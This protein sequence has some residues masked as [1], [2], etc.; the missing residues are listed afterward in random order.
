MLSTVKA[1]YESKEY[2]SVV[3]ILKETLKPQRNTFVEIPSYH[4][5][6]RYNQYV[7]MLNSFLKLKNYHVC[8]FYTFNNYY[9]IIYFTLYTYLYRNYLNGVSHAYM[10]GF[11]SIVK[12]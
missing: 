12:V 3:S 7:F 6:T 5:M 4:T 11:Y 2:T 9:N 10:R 8:I 1:L